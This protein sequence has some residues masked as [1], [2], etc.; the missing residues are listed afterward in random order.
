MARAGL[1][2][3]GFPA[4]LG[5]DGARRSR[6]SSLLRA[7]RS[8]KG[9]AGAALLLVLV[10]VAL[11]AAVA[12]AA[13]RSAHA[14]SEAARLFVREVVADE[15]SR[16]AID[17]ARAEISALDSVAQ[18]R[19]QLRY[20]LGAASLTVDFLSENGRIDWHRAAPPL[21]NAVLLGA[22]LS[23]RQAGL[24]TSSI[25]LSDPTITGNGGM[26]RKAAHMGFAP[27][28]PPSGA[29]GAVTAP[30]SVSQPRPQSLAALMSLPG[31]TPEVFARIAPLFSPCAGSGP[32]DPG[33]ASLP[34]VAA[35]MEG[36][37]GRATAFLAQQAEREPDA[38]TPSQFPS[39][40]QSFVASTAKTASGVRLDVT[41]EVDG[42]IRRHT[43]VL[44]VPSGDFAAADLLDWTL[45][46]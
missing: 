46:P 40:M 26:G 16:A 13:L 2:P 28:P 6:A 9:E 39:S 11:L 5:A 4:P 32:I 1:A 33:I 21:L 35:L 25:A 31:I 30:T 43:G 3:H 18:R 37:A 7:G 12:G 8:R 45:L 44:C 19:G 42:L 20:R 29:Q 41:V 17:L 34:I 22:G 24:L 15:A 38:A 23:E 10:A 27:P 14:T 36:D